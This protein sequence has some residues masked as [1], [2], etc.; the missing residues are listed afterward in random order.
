M[1]S[2]TL[3]NLYVIRKIEAIHLGSKVLYVTKWINGKFKAWMANPHQCFLRM[4]MHGHAGRQDFLN[5]YS[6]LMYRTDQG[7]R[8]GLRPRPWLCINKGALLL[9]LTTLSFNACRLYGWCFLNLSCSFC[10]PVQKGS[11]LSKKMGG[12]VANFLSR[13]YTRNATCRCCS[14]TCV[15]VYYFFQSRACVYR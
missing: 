4:S 12:R 2:I 7:Y 14:H 6:R 1:C 11:C 15:P 9:N 10:L 13:I 8:Y 5:Q 3:L